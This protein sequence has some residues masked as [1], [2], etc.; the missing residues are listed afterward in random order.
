MVKMKQK[1][2]MIYAVHSLL[3][4]MFFLSA[5]FSGV[6]LVCPD[7]AIAAS[8]AE[9]DRDVNAALKSLYVSSPVAKELSTKA[10]G[11]PRFSE[12]R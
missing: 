10:K 5:M 8:A 2:Q 7:P 1:T 11:I 3:Y 12:Y 9:I 4:L 6:N